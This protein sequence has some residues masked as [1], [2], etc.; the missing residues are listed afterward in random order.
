KCV[1]CREPPP[2]GGAS[3]IS[4]RL[5][6]SSPVTYTFMSRSPRFTWPVGTSSAVVTGEVRRTAATTP[7]TAQRTTAATAHEM[8]RLL[9]I[10][11]RL[12]LLFSY[13]FTLSPSD[14]L[15]PLDLRR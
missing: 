11:T 1:I 5:A 3:S 10:A 7:T 9:F 2:I 14:L 12:L 13:S 15:A 6:R 8:A 4:E